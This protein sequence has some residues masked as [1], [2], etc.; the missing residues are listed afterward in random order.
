MRRKEIPNATAYTVLDDGTVERQLNEKSREKVKHHV[1]PN[2]YHC[3]NVKLDNGKWRTLL[4]HRLVLEAWRGPCPEFYTAH[5]KDNDRSNNALTNLEWAFKGSC[6]PSKRREEQ[7]LD[8]DDL[9]H[10]IAKAEKLLRELG[11]DVDDETT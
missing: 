1:L 7:L 10:Q 3:V 2:G 4:V 8:G 9:D 6:A 11:V 5:F